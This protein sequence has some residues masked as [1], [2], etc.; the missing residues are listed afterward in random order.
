ME[1]PEAIIMVYDLT[2]RRSMTEPVVSPSGM[3]TMITNYCRGILPCPFCDSWT[4]MGDVSV[5]HKDGR[6]VG[7]GIPLFHF[8]EAGHPITTEDIDGE[9]LVSIM[10]DA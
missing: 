5:H 4:G 9:M 7:F 8:A 6:S 2:E 10:Q 1:I 3:V